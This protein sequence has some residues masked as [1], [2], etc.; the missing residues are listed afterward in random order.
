MSKRRKCDTSGNDLFIPSAFQERFGS[1]GN[2]LCETLWCFS[3]DLVGLVSEY[4][5]CPTAKLHSVPQK[6]TDMYWTH[7]HPYPCN[8]TE[9]AMKHHP[10][11]QTIWII[12][13]GSCRVMDDQGNKCFHL[14][15]TGNQYYLTCSFTD[16]DETIMST[17]DC[18][19]HAFYSHNGQ[20]KCVIVNLQSDVNQ[21]RIYGLDV[22]KN[23]IFATTLLK[24]VI[25]DRTTGQRINKWFCTSTGDVSISK[26]NPEHV[27]TMLGNQNAGCMK[28]LDMNGDVIK[29]F[30]PKLHSPWSFVQDR[31]Q[32]WIIADALMKTVYVISE[33]GDPVTQFS[34]NDEPYALCI[35][36]QGKLWVGYSTGICVYTW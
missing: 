14:N 3:L 20:F 30:G 27:Y 26:V 10:V 4:L 16:Q 17:R 12:Y 29:Q 11:H 19:L 25:V 22:W 24:T 5:I 9:L 8:G 18:D 21:E 28:M 6:C 31:N 2:V 32:Q 34:T 13:K 1:M 36:G 33:Q 15:Q 7:E 23:Y 35:D